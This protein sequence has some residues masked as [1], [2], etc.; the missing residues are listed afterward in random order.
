MAITPVPDLLVQRS[1]QLLL[2]GRTLLHTRAR[3]PTAQNSVA[4]FA[5]DTALRNQTGNLFTKSCSSKWSNGKGP[6]TAGGPQ[7]LFCDLVNLLL[8]TQHSTRI[9]FMGS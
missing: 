9:V 2:V 5:R 3:G 1:D 4:A 8:K 6:C 7:Y